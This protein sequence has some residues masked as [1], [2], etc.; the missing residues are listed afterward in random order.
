VLELGGAIAVVVGVVE[1]LRAAVGKLPADFSG[2]IMER[3]RKRWTAAL[4]RVGVLAHGAV[5]AVAGY[6]VFLAGLHANPRGLSGTASALRTIKH[7]ENGPVLFALAAVGLIAYG[8]SLL[9][10]AAHRRKR[11]A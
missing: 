10:L 1:A 7:A 2:V 9:L 6:S 3:A 8:L 4:A 11:S 5:V